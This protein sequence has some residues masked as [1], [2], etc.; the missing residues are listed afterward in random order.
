MVPS[1]QCADRL[2]LFMG[3]ASKSLWNDAMEYTGRK[4]VSP[5]LSFGG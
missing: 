3:E 5:N 2:L 4:S 1:Q